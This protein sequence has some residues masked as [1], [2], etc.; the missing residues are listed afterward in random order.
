MVDATDRARLL[1]IADRLGQVR[2]GSVEADE[3]IHRALGRAGAAPAYTGSAG[4]LSDG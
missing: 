2:A 4:G 3:T 1:R